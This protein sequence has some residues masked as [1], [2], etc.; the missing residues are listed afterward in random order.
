MDAKALFKLDPMAGISYA[1]YN[2]VKKGK[3]SFEDFLLNY[4]SLE[5]NEGK[6]NWLTNLMSREGGFNKLA[7]SPELLSSLDLSSFNF[8][9]SLS[10]SNFLATKADSYKLQALSMLQKKGYSDK[11]LEAFSSIS[12]FKNPLLG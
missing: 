6:N 7:S 3:G 11:E 5:A 10:T 8:S 4:N 2:S 1:Q 9:T 12:S